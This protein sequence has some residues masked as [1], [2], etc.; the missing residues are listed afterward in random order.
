M[1]RQQVPFLEDQ[2]GIAVQAGMIIRQPIFNLSRFRCMMH[3]YF[4]MHDNPGQKRQ[5]KSRTRSK[6]DN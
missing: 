3:E 4:K 1:I 6:G 2:L 5:E